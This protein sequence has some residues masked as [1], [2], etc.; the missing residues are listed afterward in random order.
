MGSQDEERSSRID[1]QNCSHHQ[2]VMQS[3]YHGSSNSRSTESQHHCLSET[4]SVQHLQMKSNQCNSWA[5]RHRQK[6]WG[7]SLRGSRSLILILLDH[8]KADLESNLI[9]SGE[10][11]GTQDQASCIMLAIMISS[12]EW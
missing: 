4:V 3:Y 7:S 6:S 8:S 5:T 9:N 2:T 1:E 10:I 12:E 11:T